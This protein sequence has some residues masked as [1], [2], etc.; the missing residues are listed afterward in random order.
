MTTYFIKGGLLQELFLFWSPLSFQFRIDLFFDLIWWNKHIFDLIWYIYLNDIRPF[1]HANAG[2]TFSQNESLPPD[3]IESPLLLQTTVPQILLIT[4]LPCLFYSALYPSLRHTQSSS[5]W[6][7]LILA[8]PHHMP[9]PPQSF[10]T[11]HFRY[12]HYIYLLFGWLAGLFVGP[13]VNFVLFV[14]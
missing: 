8:T 5:S 6:Y 1:V 7:P 4:L 3:S 14:G 12:F 10:S 13:L 9:K 2:R 11:H